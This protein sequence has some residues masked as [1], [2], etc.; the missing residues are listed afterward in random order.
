[1]E[2]F[3]SEVV[4]VGHEGHFTILL[5]TCFLFTSWYLEELEDLEDDDIALGLGPHYELKTCGR[6]RC[7]TIRLRYTFGH[8]PAVDRFRFR[9]Q[10]ISLSL[11]FSTFA[12][13]YSCRNVKACQ[14]TFDGSYLKIKINYE[15]NNIN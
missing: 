5:E 10:K 15:I 4:I 3:I 7:K 6:F 12:S 13:H 2:E 1:L 11:K 14:N 9:Y 8:R